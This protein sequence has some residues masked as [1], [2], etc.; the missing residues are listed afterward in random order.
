[1]QQQM[2]PFRIG[3]DYRL[4][5]C[6]EPLPG[7]CCGIWGGERLLVGIQKLKVCNRRRI[8]PELGQTCGHWKAMESEK[9][10]N[11]SSVFIQT[12]K[13]ENEIA[14]MFPHE[15]PRRTKL[16]P[17]AH[18]RFRGSLHRKICFILQL[19]TWK[20]SL[21]SISPS[22]TTTAPLLPTRRHLE[23]IRDV[24]SWRLGCNQD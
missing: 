2:P 5:I 14:E 11:Q 9:R 6:R 7:S 12:R 16:H 23:A 21:L 8:Q 4:F 19:V 10:Q 20:P 1:M 18:C 3:E 17:V 15:L 24:V 13:W 22:S